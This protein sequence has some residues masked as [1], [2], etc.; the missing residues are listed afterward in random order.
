MS[1]VGLPGNLGNVD[2]EI[3]SRKMEKLWTP[4]VLTTMREKVKIGWE[5]L[6]GAH[7]H[8]IT[9]SVEITES[10]RCGSYGDDIECKTDIEIKRQG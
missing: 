7:R 9:L 8:H 1:C 6:N 3:Q 4:S 10:L 5:A 2:G